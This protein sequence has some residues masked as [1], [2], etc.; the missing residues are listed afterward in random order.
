MKETKAFTGV[1]NML[2]EAMEKILHKTQVEPEIQVV[3][4]NIPSKV[5]YAQSSSL[6]GHWSGFTPE[7]EMMSDPPE[8]T[9]LR[10]MYIPKPPKRC[11]F[12][13]PPPK[14]SEHDEWVEFMLKEFPMLGAMVQKDCGC[15]WKVLK[16]HEGTSIEPVNKW[17]QWKYCMKHSYPTSHLAPYVLSDEEG[18]KL[19]AA[20]EEVV[21]SNT[22]P[23][24]VIGNL[25][26]MEQYYKLHETS[27]AK[28]YFATHSEA[29]EDLLK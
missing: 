27:N 12:V 26:T 14:L 24:T 1:K 22:M 16:I 5:P 29:G 15:G 13:P 23:S 7:D 9:S 25:G 8:M 17:Q 2:K 4:S 18:Q 10:D 19:Q 28:S 20:Y 11:G 6:C 3:Q 21:H